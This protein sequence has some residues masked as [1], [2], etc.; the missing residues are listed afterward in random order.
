MHTSSRM[1]VSDRKLAAN[2]ANA[3]KSTGPKTERGKENS[4]RNA[5]KH[6]LLS[7]SIVLEGGESKERFAAILNSFMAE[8]RPETPNEEVFVEKMAVSHWRLR[9]LW[10]CESASIKREMQR[11]TGA[12]LE[13]D[14]PTRAMLAMNSLSK[15]THHHELMCRYENLFDREHYRAI[16][17]IKTLREEK[18]AREARERRR[19][20]ARAE[21]THRA[22]ENKEQPDNYEPTQTPGEPTESTNE[23]TPETLKPTEC[24]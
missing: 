13:A 21:G 15:D 23:P 6:G 8:F 9:R 24:L 14:A 11:Q 3:A 10:A 1:P 22:H 18:D 20:N 5:I 16:A 2:Q 4:S 17:G 7:N 12:D 19:K